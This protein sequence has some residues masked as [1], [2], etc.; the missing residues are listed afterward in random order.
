MDTQSLKE[1]I[2]KNVYHI[3]AQKH[4]ALHRHAKHDELFYCM[5]GKGYGVLEDKEV[6]LHVGEVFTVPAG[7]M[8]ALRAQDELIVASFLIPRIEE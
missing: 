8:H 7:V 3:D 4:V 1:A 6:A 5:A 2:V